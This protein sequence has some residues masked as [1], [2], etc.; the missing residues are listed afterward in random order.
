MNLNY[1][2]VDSFETQESVLY[3]LKG[4]KIEGFVAGDIVLWDGK[5]KI[6]VDQE[7][8]TTKNY[9]KWIF[10]PIGVVVIPE[11]H[12]D[13]GKA[14]M[15][16]TRWMSCD[17]PENGDTEDGDGTVME[18]GGDNSVNI[19]ALSDYTAVPIINEVNNQPITSANSS[20][21]YLSSDNPSWTGSTNRNDSGTRWVYRFGNKIASPYAS[22]GTPNQT[23]RAT[24][25]SGGTIFNPLSDF[26]G[27]GNTDKILETRGEKDYV[28]WKPTANAPE[29]YP[30]ASCCDM[31]HTVGTKQ[32][33]WYLPSCGEFGYVV[34]RL[35]TILNVMKKIGGSEITDN[36]YGY[37]YWTSTEWANEDRCDAWNIGL[38]DGMVSHSLAGKNGNLK[39]SA[40]YKL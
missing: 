14:R 6:V 30:A 17:D 38:A 37:N 19:S 7:S 5:K 23:Y 10:T 2:H 1:P 24:S 39:V 3:S 8:Y 28:S 36:H 34:A 12:M 31:Y 27:R 18:W 21:G 11:N 22:D 35:G 20:G 15:M 32:G 9:P 13:D 33:D 16:A 40:F 29:D 25:Y 26:D 4:V